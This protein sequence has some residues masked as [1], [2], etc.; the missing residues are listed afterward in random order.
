MKIV[1]FGSSDF[2]IESLKTLIGKHQILAVFTQPDKKKGRHLLSSATP[3]KSYALK[4]KLKVFQPRDICS[5]ETNA[6]LK[7][8]D[9]DLFVVVS[10]GTIFS[11]EVL[12]IPKFYCINLHASILP[13]WRGASPINQA[14]IHGDKIS[15][16]TVIKMNEFMDRGSIMLTKSINIEENEHAL[17][18]ELKLG[19]LGGNALVEAID[20]IERNKVKLVCQNDDLAL[21]AHKLKKQD[22]LIN[23]QDKALKIHNQV[24]GFIPWPCAY[25]YYQNKLLK[26][27]KTR[28]VGHNIEN[29]VK[30]VGEII[31]IEKDNGIIVSTGFGQLLLERVQLAGKRVISAYDFAMGQRLVKGDIIM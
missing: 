5:V 3:V 1:F 21:I 9:A 25:I 22:G 10:F 16:V 13:R 15:G 31:C 18:L 8:F 23:W 11:K 6:F 29:Q 27:L 4:N 30:N 19:A 17:S 28:V 12:D 14:I 26:I 24:R 20:L 2:S 7:S